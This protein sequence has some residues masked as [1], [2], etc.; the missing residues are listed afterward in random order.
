M[1]EGKRGNTPVLDE[2]LDD[3]LDDELTELEKALRLLE[4][5]TNESMGG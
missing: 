5:Q 3:I 1:I 2:D 4:L